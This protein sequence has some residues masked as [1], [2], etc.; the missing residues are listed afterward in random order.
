MLLVLQCDLSKI[1]NK[2]LIKLREA[3]RRKLKR[4]EKEYVKTFDEKVHH[5]QPHDY[6]RKLVQ[7]AIMRRALVK[8]EEDSTQK[9]A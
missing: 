5:T 3:I 7:E 6:L 1:E 2:Y 4:E 8:R 9:Q